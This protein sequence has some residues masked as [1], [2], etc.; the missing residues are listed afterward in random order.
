LRGGSLCRRQASLQHLL[1]CIP[2]INQRI[3]ALPPSRRAPV[4]RRVPRPDPVGQVGRAALY[5]P[6][7]PRIST[8]SPHISPHLPTS[9][10]ISPHL[11]TSAHASPTS[12]PCTRHGHALTKQRTRGLYLPISPHISG[13]WCAPLY[14]PISPPYL[15]ISSHISPSRA[16]DARR[17]RESEWPIWVKSAL[18]HISAIS[19]HISPI[20]PHALTKQRTRG[21]GAPPGAVIDDAFLALIRAMPRGGR[22]SLVAVQRVAS[23]SV[24]RVGRRCCGWTPHRGRAALSQRGSEGGA[25]GGLSLH[26]CSCE[27]AALLFSRG[28]GGDDAAWC[29]RTCGPRRRGAPGPPPRFRGTQKQ[30]NLRW[31]KKGAV[32]RLPHRL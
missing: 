13:K 14:L 28:G 6:I 10:H 27:Q 15:P 22:S 24:L 8:I 3:S 30:G 1:P 26:T 18:D 2:V 20:A 16:N 9:P 12:T 11:P 4:R 23:A 32:N 19:L 29:C 17:S 25:R 21:L 7:S 5:L 31:G